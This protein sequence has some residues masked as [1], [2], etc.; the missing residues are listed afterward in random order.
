MAAPA[1]AT[2]AAKGDASAASTA[3]GDDRAAHADAGTESATTS[4]SSSSSSSSS[5]S[6]PKDDDDD[7]GEEEEETCGFCKYMKGG[8][9]KDVFV[10]WE[11]CVD[12]AK[13]TDEDFVEV[14]YEATSALRD[15]MLKDPEY[16]G[17]MTGE[18]EDDDDGESA[19]GDAPA[20]VASEG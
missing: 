5:A 12:K 19:K 17:P 13:E 10:A 16:Y 2:T 18:S 14:C 3:P 7:D 9:C 1:V 15:C 8:S 20:A 6:Q 4:S 11:A